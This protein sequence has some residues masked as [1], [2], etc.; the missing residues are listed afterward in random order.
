MKSSNHVYM[1]VPVIM[2]KDC[3]WRSVSVGEWHKWI[4]GTSKVQ[5]GGEEETISVLW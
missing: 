3:A 4:I 5:G 2:G 1:F